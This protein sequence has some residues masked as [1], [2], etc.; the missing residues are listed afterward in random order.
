MK[1][2]SKK[3]II[4]AVAIILGIALLALVA[5]R[6]SQDNKEI[7]ARS[8]EIKTEVS[9]ILANHDME[10]ESENILVSFSRR[11][12]EDNMHFKLKLMINDLDEGDYDDYEEMCLLY[13]DLL[14]WGEESN[15]ELDCIISGED[16]YTFEKDYTYEDTYKLFNGDEC[17]WWSYGPDSGYWDPDDDEY[18]EE[19]PSCGKAISTWRRENYTY[20]EDCY[21]KKGFVEDDDY[22]SEST[23]VG[24]CTICGKDGYNEFQGYAYCDEHYTDAVLWAL[25]N[26][27]N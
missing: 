7:E 19:C 25:D 8:A 16:T 26:V 21:E 15:T 6:N 17:V 1:N 4:L 9:E 3:K 2:L 24:K 10:A 22:S 20:C 18:S 23:Y 11:D 13:R 27:S 14:E 5:Y 12:D